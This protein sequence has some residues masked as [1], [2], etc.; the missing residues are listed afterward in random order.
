MRAAKVLATWF[1]CGL[2]PYGPGT[3]GSLGAL[4][5][6]FLAARYLG[7]NGFQVA[8]CSIVLFFP[9][10]WAS[11]ACARDKSLKDPG[12]VVVDEVVGQWIT[13]AGADRLDWKAL[14]AAFVLFRFFDILKPFGA[15]RLEK[16]PGGLGIV[17]DDALAGLY[18]AVVLFIMRLVNLF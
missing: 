6:A 1:G 12:F 13:L 4:L 3:V 16:L 17:A 5:P 8:L 15:R 14:L 9:A 10:V 18:A 11:E 2:F 7:W